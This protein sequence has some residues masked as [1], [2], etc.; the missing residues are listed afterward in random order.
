M[1]VSIVYALPEEQWLEALDVPEGCTVEQALNMSQAMTKFP[2]IDLAINKVGIFAK[3]AKLTQVL[4]DGERVE[5]Y[6]G[7]PKKPRDAHA[8]DDKKERIRAKKERKKVED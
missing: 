1:H 2:D 5:I 3:L 6:R 4:Q 7:L 8:N